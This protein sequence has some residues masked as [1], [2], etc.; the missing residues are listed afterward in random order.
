MAKG[1]DEEAVRIVHEVASRNGKT[2]S[3]SLEDL[4]ACETIVGAA[5]PGAPTGVDTSNVAAFQ[6]KIETLKLSHVRS[7]FSTKKLA[8]STGMIMAAWGT[9]FA[10]MSLVL[11]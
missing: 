6:R 4:R 9:S 5:V 10:S 7:L 3:L 1:R 2:T 8:I 11:S